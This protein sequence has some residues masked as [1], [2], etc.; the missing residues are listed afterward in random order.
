[1]LPRNAEPSPDL[2]RR[3]RGVAGTTTLVRCRRYFVA[4][5]DQLETTGRSLRLRGELLRRIEEQGTDGSEFLTGNFSWSCTWDLL[6]GGDGVVYATYGAWCLFFDRQLV[7]DVL[8]ILE[9]APGDDLGAFRAIVAWE[10]SRACWRK[11]VGPHCR[12]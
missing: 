3:L 7:A 11:P 8:G 9:A 12:A 6:K 10:A 4:S 2:L 5:V 1:M